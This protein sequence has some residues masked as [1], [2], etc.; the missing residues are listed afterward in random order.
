MVRVTKKELNKRLRILEKN[1]N[2]KDSGKEVLSIGRTTTGEYYRRGYP[3]KIF[4]EL[5]ELRKF[6][7]SQK[8]KKQHIY[9]TGPYRK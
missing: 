3:D 1:Q 9:I 5:V 6:Y 7:S 2:L 8:P 4:K